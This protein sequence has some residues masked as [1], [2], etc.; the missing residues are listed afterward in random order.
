M[1]EQ[2]CRKG[3]HGGKLATRKQKKNR[4]SLGDPEGY[5]EEGGR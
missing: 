4:P 1:L 5:I 2:H 3:E